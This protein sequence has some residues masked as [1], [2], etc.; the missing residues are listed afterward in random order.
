[1]ITQDAFITGRI[2]IGTI[3]SKMNGHNKKRKEFII[4]ILMLFLGMRGRVNFLQLSRQGG[5]NEKSYRYQFEKNFNWLDFNKIFVK[6]ECSNEVIIGFDPSHISKSGKS[7]PGLGN[8]YSGCAGAYK[9]GL[10]IGS[11]AVIDVDQNTA[12]H[13]EAVASP[14]AK[15][16]TIGSS[17]TLVDHYAEI[18][19]DRSHELSEL[20][21]ILVC[22]GYFAKIKY[23][24]AVCD[25]TSMELISRMRDDANLQY[26]YNGDRQNG[27]G[28]P[29]Q[30]AG[31][32][33]TKKIDRRRFEKVYSDSE[34]TI[35]SAVVYSV[36]LKR[37]I[38][39]CYVN[40]HKEKV[41]DVV[42]LFFST[43][44]ERSSDQILKYYRSRFQMEFIFRDAKQSTGL[45]NCQAR[46]IN[47]L[48]FHYNASMSA[49][50]IAKTILR[51]GVPKNESISLCITD[52]KTE[53]QNR[54]MLKRI[55][56]IYGFDHNLIK[57]DDIYKQVLD[58][59][60][61]AA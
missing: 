22:D 33:D 9:R 13:L 16:D 51:K 5:K 8:F 48:H 59:G 36:G 45:Q 35:Y 21:N 4:H 31:K 44:L 42:K 50:S 53:L 58:Y 49:V 19:I 30:Y 32:I 23:V 61:I 56:S 54:I 34:K 24:D 57:I 6:Q 28:R 41:K 26:L 29:R 17:K 27:R 14:P 25:H 43:N 7:T 18:L 60:K 46:S 3:L 38:K 39:L 37:K 12:Y 11:F 1:M 10:E 55:F 15:K 40:F 20:S 52:V 2:L 47:K